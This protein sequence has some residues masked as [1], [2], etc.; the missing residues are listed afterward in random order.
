MCC[1]FSPPVP[2]N[3]PSVV[4]VPDAN[5]VQDIV[6]LA[7]NVAITRSHPD[8]YALELGSAVL[9]GSFYSTRL[10]ID[11][12]KNA[13]LVYS[14]GSDINAGR[15]R[16][17]YFIQYASDPENVLKASAIAV[18]ELKQMQDSPVTE[19]ELAR[20]KALL[21]RQIPLGES[22]IGSIA[23]GLAG[24]WELDLPLDEPT[25]AA[26]RYIALG[27]AEIQAAFKKWIRPDDLVR[28]SQGP[29]PQ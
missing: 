12:R 23:R 2:G 10:S 18:R 22:S 6:V 26:Q 15:T 8:Y 19:E 4:A 21:L 20:V 16:A 17:N 13:G 3:A 1:C 29:T 9:G 14:V 25:L 28:V 7:E 27:P 24:R 5:R 11:L